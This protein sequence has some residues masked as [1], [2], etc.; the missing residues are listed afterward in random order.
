MKRVFLIGFMGAGKTTLGREVSQRLSLP[1]FDL[2]E[3]IVRDAGRSVS[4]IFRAEGEE[5]FR[6][7]EARALR[8]LVDEPRGIIAT[9]GGTFEAEEN[10]EIIRK[11]GVSIWLDVPTDVL[12][13]RVTGRNR[14]LWRNEAAA[15]DLAERRKRSYRMANIRLELGDDSAENNV[16][17]LEALCVSLS[18]SIGRDS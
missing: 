7:R 15:R 4:E 10:R 17:K 2:D 1:F 16:S 6:G 3:R 13:T 9:G 8:A 5:G 14:P 11:T 18:T 12:L